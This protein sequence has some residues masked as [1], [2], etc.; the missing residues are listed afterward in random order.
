[1]GDLPVGAV[2]TE[3]VLGALEPIWRAKSETA[4]RVRGRIE[5]VLDYAKTRGWRA[6]E[7]PARW[8]GHLD[9]LLPARNKVAKVE[10]HAALPWQEICQFIALLHQQVGVAARALEFAILSAA[11]TG[12]V[13]GAAW[14]EIDLQA[15]VWTAQPAE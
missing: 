2:R 14:Q 13:I 15:A 10:Q 4:S 5:A 3:H 7:S 11:R 12:E 9:H 6:G 8:K 1:M